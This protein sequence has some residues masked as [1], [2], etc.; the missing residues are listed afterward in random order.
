MTRRR[1][2]AM[3]GF[4]LLATLALGGCPQAGQSALDAPLAPTVAGTYLVAQRDGAV[5]YFEVPTLGGRGEW[6][7]AGPA[8][9][10]MGDGFYHYEFSDGWTTTYVLGDSDPDGD[11]QLYDPM[12][13]AE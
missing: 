6:V 8:D 9:W 12:P 1:P 2:L 13:P 4:V 10:Y 7:E 5:S 11:L 3:S